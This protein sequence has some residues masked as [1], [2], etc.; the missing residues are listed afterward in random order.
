MIS[1]LKN[2][3]YELMK[4]VKK[5]DSDAFQELF[6]TL[7]EPLYRNAKSILLDEDIAKD[8]VQEVWVDF[9]QRRHHIKNENIEGYLM[10]STKFSVYKELSRNPLKTEHL[11]Y[12]EAVESDGTADDHLIYSQTQQMISKSV[13]ELPKRCQEIFKMSREDQLSNAEIATQLN[14]SKRTVETQISY[15]LKSLKVRL[16]TYMLSVF[17]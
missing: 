12:L 16:S 9:W 15:A 17:F 10:Q 14:I 4:R 8:I 7:W 6:N 1:K 2:T 13:D 3:T 5:D 11:T